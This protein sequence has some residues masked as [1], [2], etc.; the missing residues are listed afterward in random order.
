MSH[1][2]ISHIHDQSLQL[3]DLLVDLIA[4]YTNLYKLV[5]ILC[6]V[7]GVL[8]A[9]GTVTALILLT[10]DMADVFETVLIAVKRLPPLAIVSNPDLLNYLIVRNSAGAKMQM[11]PSQNIVYYSPLGVMSVTSHGIIDFMNQAVTQTLGYS[12]E[13]LLGQPIRLILHPDDGPSFE[14][15]ISAGNSF[16]EEMYLVNDDGSDLLCRIAMFVDTA[17]H[18]IVTIDDI[19]NLVEDRE[20]A[21]EA[22]EAS[23]KLLNSIVPSQLIG[24]ISS[25]ECIAC[26]ATVASVMFIEIARFNSIS[27][28]HTPQQVL[29]T[30]NTIFRTFESGIAEFSHLTRV[31]V[32]GA[33]YLLASGLFEE[34]GDEPTE[35]IFM[36]G[37]K[38]LEDL[39]DMNSKLNAEI[40]I[41]IGMATGGPVTA[42]MFGT[43]GLLFDIIGKPIGRAKQLLTLAPMSA[44][45]LDVESQRKLGK[46]GFQ[47]DLKPT[48]TRDV[49]FVFSLAGSG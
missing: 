1:V 16:Q 35:Q 34:A 42:G 15:R 26:R 28:Q 44:I 38:C 48:N 20:R 21:Q 30:V 10:R 14:E 11:T 4:H 45:H 17:G 49:T 33:E 18:R 40:Q 23:A 32:A 43:E 47:G 13:Q 8:F 36:Y 46:T 12:P 19:T 9:L 27:A 3:E 37:V 25:N 39:E 24:E 31:S 41:R 22:A 2:V 7:G 29:G 6:Y 5:L